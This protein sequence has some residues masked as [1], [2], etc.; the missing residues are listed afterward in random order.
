M[1]RDFP[2][3]FKLQF[4]EKRFGV[5]NT[6]IPNSGA[7]SDLGPCHSIGVGLTWWEIFSEPK[8][9]FRRITWSLY[10]YQGK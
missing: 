2:R 4:K 1:V 7:L 8:S 10:G 3:H 6:S 5:Q 9:K